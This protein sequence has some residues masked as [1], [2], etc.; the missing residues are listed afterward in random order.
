MGLRVL[1]ISGHDF[2]GYPNNIA[3][4]PLTLK[5]MRLRGW[6]VDF[7][8]NTKDYGIDEISNI[9]GEPPKYLEAGIRIHRIPMPIYNPI[10]WKILGLS[11][12]GKSIRQ[13]LA[14]DIMFPYYIRKYA[15]PFAKIADVIYGYEVYGV[16]VGRKLASKYN[17]PMISRFQGTFALEWL[18]MARKSILGR[19][20]SF[21]YFIHWKALE[22]ESQLIIM[23]D[24]GTNG[25][26]VLK[27]LG[28]KSPVKFWKN[29]VDTRPSGI[30]K[31]E[32]RRALGLPTD[33]NISI[34]V[35]RLVRWKRVERIIKAYALVINEVPNVLHIIV[36][37]G[38]EKRNLIELSKKLNVDKNIIFTGHQ[39]SNMTIKFME[40]SDVFISMYD[41]SNV[42][43]PLLDA[44]KLGLPIVTIDNGDTAS[45]IKDRYNGILLKYYDETA[46][47]NALIEIFLNKN[48]AK[49]ISEKALESGKRIWTWKERLNAELD[50]IEKIVASWK[51]K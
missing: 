6:E 49:Y 23:T 36:G 25:L 44:M 43:N 30:H 3:P 21:R 34:S 37:E 7:I 31:H 33:H 14:M 18:K 41:I 51:A 45:L 40:A 2:W 9:Y 26:R 11:K 42:C 1:M 13:R 50:E 10:I 29:G 5:Y 38:P 4:L 48:L 32:L 19:M 27:E 46:L 15:E 16:I 24:D 28:N 35:S 47:K 39:S 12:L 17:K 20:N 22:T 8:T